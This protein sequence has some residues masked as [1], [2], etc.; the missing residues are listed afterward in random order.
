MVSRPLAPAGVPAGALMTVPGASGGD[1]AAVGGGM[2]QAGGTWGGGPGAMGARGL[3]GMGGLSVV[4]PGESVEGE[5]GA[6]GLSPTTVE[7]TGASLLPRG[8]IV[9]PAQSPLGSPI[10]G[11]PLASPLRRTLFGTPPGTPSS[12]GGVPGVKL[13]SPTP[14]EAAKHRLFR[15]EAIR[16]RGREKE[17]ERRKDK[18]GADGGGAGR[19]AG[20]GAGYSRMP[21]RPTAEEAEQATGGLPRVT[22]G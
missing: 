22:A 10:R 12:G 5:E 20:T 7:A 4:I 2:G 8:A 16:E 11:A 18:D 6:M 14:A 13:V 17:G 9:S 21:A 19:G 3:G 15:R 1:M